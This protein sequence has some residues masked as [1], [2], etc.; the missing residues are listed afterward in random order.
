MKVITRFAPSPTGYLHIGSARTAIFNYLFAKHFGGKF[1]LRV[2]DTDKARST[3]SATKAIIDGM[4]WLGIDHDGEIVFQSTREK[5]HAEVARSL[6]ELGKA[7]KCFATQ[8]E[9]DEKRQEV[10]KAGGSFLFQSPWRDADE[11]SHPKDLPYVIRL[12]APREGKTIIQDLVQ[13]EVVVSN[14]VLDDMVLLRGD[15]TPTYMLAVV[16]DD[17][18]MDVTHIIRGDDH[19]NNAFRQKILYEAAGFSVPVMAHIPL[20]HGA[21]GAKLSKRHGAVGVEGY[22]D[23]GYLPD[24]LF[25]YL[26]RLGWSHGDLDIITKD[27]AIEWFDGKHIGKA[28]ARIDFDKMKFINAHYLRAMSNEE[29]LQIIQNEW[30][31]SEIKMDDVTKG[32]LLKAM[33]EIKVRSELTKDLADLATIYHYDNIYAVS[34]EA[35]AVIDAADKVLIE[36]IRQ[37]IKDLQDWNKD[38]IQAGF[39]ALAEERGLKLGAIMNPVRCILTGRAASPSVFEIIEVLGKDVVLSR[40]DQLF[41][42][43]A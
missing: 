35:R 33:D 42:A 34:E 7:Y 3:E 32:Y 11:V 21:D 38:S 40:F 9:I 10:I 39:K 15:G 13:G 36:S 26:L 27:Q 30:N 6:V 16:V 17:H 29:L 1:L 28:A 23:M 25:N 24:A 41:R 4:K 18:D 5:R 12:K 31:L 37:M 14:D 20:I 43:S 8:E 22:R 2:E 19:L